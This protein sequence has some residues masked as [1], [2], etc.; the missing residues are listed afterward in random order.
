[1]GNPTMASYVMNTSV[2]GYVGY[3][4]LYCRYLG[5]KYQAMGSFVK[6]LEIFTPR[7]DSALTL[8]SGPSSLVPPYISK[9]L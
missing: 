7:E 8:S 9:N 5:Y 3:G 4:Y 1:M 6:G 2:Y